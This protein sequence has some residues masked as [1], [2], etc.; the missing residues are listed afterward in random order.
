MARVLATLSIWL[1]ARTLVAPSW[2]RALLAAA[3][4]VAAALTRTQLA[5]LLVVLLLGL[6][7]V[8]WQSE[9][10]RRWR[11]GWSTWDW[12]GA[13]T[14][15]VGV[16]LGFSALVG[17]YSTSW[18]N[19]TGFYKERIFDHGVW[20]MGAL[21]IGIG[22]V[23]MVVGIA[24][25]ARPRDEER[26]P[27]TRAFVATS[28]AG[29]RPPSRSAAK[30]I[31]NDVVPPVA[32]GRFRS[33]AAVQMV[34]SMRPATSTARREGGHPVNPRSKGAEAATAVAA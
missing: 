34:A 10:G 5:V 8:G 9:R 12:A 3:A 33:R 18:R 30:S 27:R 23:P 24:A 15:G 16:A 20:A 25:L 14:L 19:T 11:A 32:N 22:I 1:T 6:L 4:A 26:D 29:V 21:A 31:T 7:W 17:H 28:V 2:K 13:V